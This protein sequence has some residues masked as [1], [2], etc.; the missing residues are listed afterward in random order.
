MPT[1]KALFPGAAI[2]LLMS[3][4]LYA[5]GTRG[6]VFAIEHAELLDVNLYWSWPLFLA[7][8]ALSRALLW[9]ID[10]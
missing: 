6:G 1:I 8:F 4:I 3:A 10:A 2:T 9:M 7:L 5:G